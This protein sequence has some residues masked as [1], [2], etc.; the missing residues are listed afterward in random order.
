LSL[1]DHTH[2]AAAQ[3]LHDAVVR[4]GL[5]DHWREYYGGKMGKSTKAVELAKAQS[6]C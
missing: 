6:D 5:P 1:I 3:L 4:D 2:A